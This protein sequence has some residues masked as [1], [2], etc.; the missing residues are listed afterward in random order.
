MFPHNTISSNF[1]YS[2]GLKYYYNPKIFLGINTGV[3]FSK[4]AFG[5]GRTNPIVYKNTTYDYYDYYISYLYIPIGIKFSFLNKCFIRPNISFDLINGF[6][7]NEKVHIHAGR[8]DIPLLSNKFRYYFLKPQI[9]V[10]C[11]FYI[12]KKYKLDIEIVWRSRAFYHTDKALAPGFKFTN[13]CL[14]ISFGYVIK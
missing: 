3:F 11:D 8:Q 12:K 14:G 1:N 13:L 9:T 2:V 7:V 10:G 4:Q 5:L 6:L